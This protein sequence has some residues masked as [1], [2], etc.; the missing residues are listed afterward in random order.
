VPYEIP[1]FRKGKQARRGRPTP[2][3]PFRVTVVGRDEARKFFNCRDD[4]E[5]RRHLR[6]LRDLGVLVHKRGRLTQ[7][8]RVGPG[9]RVSAYVCRGHV[10]DVPRRRARSVRGVLAW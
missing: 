9:E 6:G 1:D 10:G 3:E 2:T 8:V 7:P 5:L 4:A